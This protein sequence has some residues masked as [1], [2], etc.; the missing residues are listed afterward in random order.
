MK[1]LIC[2]ALTVVL[3]I[4]LFVPASFAAKEDYLWIMEEVEKSNEEIEELIEEAIEDVQELDENDKHYEKDLNKLI[5]KLEKETNKLADKMVKKAAKV[6]IEVICE[7]V[8]Y[9]IGGQS[10][11]I[12]P[13]IIIGF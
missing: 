1:K 9:Q 7:Y 4:S 11:L 12:D 5:W 6:G 10:V 2:S 8:E 3:V 13:L